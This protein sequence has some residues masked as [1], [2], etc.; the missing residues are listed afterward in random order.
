MFPYLDHLPML[1]ERLKSARK[2]KYPHDNLSQFALRIDV[3]RSTLQ[4]MEKGDLSV[5]IGRYYQAA[6]RLGLTASFD[7]LFKQ[8]TLFDD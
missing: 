2:K 3:A 1:G 4:K 8:D 6:H 7:E 5:S